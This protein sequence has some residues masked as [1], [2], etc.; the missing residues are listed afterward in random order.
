MKLKFLQSLNAS[1]T[2]NNN[3]KI[4]D[5]VKFSLYSG[6]ELMTI[7]MMDGVTTLPT[8]PQ[9][10]CVGEKSSVLGEVLKM[11]RHLY[12]TWENIA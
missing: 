5:V 8:E 1:L 6:I 9:M 2:L 3:N 7:C 4:G 11:A 12:L 10:L